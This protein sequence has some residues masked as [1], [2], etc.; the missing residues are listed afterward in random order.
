MSSASAGPLRLALTVLTACNRHA[1]SRRPDA[2]PAAVPVTI[3]MVTNV[4]WDRSVS[5]I[6]TLYPKDTA[7]IAAQVDGSVERTLV[8]FGDRV[9]TNQD[10]AFIDTASYAAQLTHRNIFIRETIREAGDA[11]GLEHDADAFPNA[12]VRQ[13]VNY[14][15]ARR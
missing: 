5:I 3:A 7:T 11:E 15:R 12:S 13:T 6:G 4:A 9:K 1:E 14:G 2:R 10:L 8:D